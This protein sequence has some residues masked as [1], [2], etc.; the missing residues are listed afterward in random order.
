LIGLEVSSGDRDAA[1]YG[2]AFVF[3][4]AAERGR[5]NVLLSCTETRN[6]KD[7]EGSIKIDRDFH[8]LLREIDEAPP[9]SIES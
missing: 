7:Q 5:S 4:P 1:D 8:G 6:D 3:D 2:A 9:G